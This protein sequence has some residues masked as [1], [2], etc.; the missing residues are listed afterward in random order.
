MIENKIKILRKAAE[1]STVQ[2]SDE[3]WCVIAGNEDM[4][5]NVAY[6]AIMDKDRVKVL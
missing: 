4:V 5:N 3:I 1:V 2:D 6:S